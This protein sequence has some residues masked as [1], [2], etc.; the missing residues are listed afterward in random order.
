MR[1]LL[2]IIGISSVGL[3]VATVSTAHAQKIFSATSGV[4]N[5]GGPGFGTLTE[6]HN[7]AGLSAAYTSDVTDFDTYIAG[8][9]THTQTF[10]GFEWF[11]ESGIGSATVTYDF[12]AVRTFD[13]FAL[14]N[15]ESSGIGRLNILGST[16]GITFSSILAGLTPPDNPL[17]P[18]DYSA[19]VFGF[20]ASSARY[21]RM[22]MSQCPQPDPGS[23]QGCAIGEVAFRSA[24]VVPEPSSY[25]L[26]ATGLLS[27][28][29]LSRRRRA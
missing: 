1:R 15:E 2:R 19:T 8:N 7:Q 29:V 27:L 18:N 14:W 4:I 12:G 28:G 24:N 17:G 5:S 16:D 25:A 3:A 6:T 13:R 20:A 21:F 22:E 23:F 9:P 11:S 26:V 10:N